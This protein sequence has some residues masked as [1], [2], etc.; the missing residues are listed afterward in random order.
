MVVF[1]TLFLTSSSTTS[2]TS[3]NSTSG[4][5]QALG[6]GTGGS[7]YTFTPEQVKAF[8]ITG[9]YE[10]DS[11]G[12]YNAFNTG[13]SA[14]G[15]IAHGSGDSSKTNTFGMPLTSMTIGQVK[16]LQAQGKLHAAGRFQFIGNSLPEAAQF[17]G[18]SDTDSFS[19]ENQNRMF[20]AFGNKY[21]T[22]RWVG[23]DKASPEERNT[24]QSAFNNW[25]S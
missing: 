2:N 25:Q 1:P 18:L 17:A 3:T 14:G 13:G 19:P 8:D 21:G 10:S 20:L 6:S 12:G 5:A 9:L 22:G 4:K 11:S 24:V 16:N 23:L 15:T 7:K